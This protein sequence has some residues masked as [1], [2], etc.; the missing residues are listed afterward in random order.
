[1]IAR[2]G[3][4][5]DYCVI[6]CQGGGWGYQFQ[7]GETSAQSSTGWPSAARAALD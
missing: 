4:G 1:M 2:C 6:D 7:H 5:P 3:N